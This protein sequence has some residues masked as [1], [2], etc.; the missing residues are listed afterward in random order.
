MNE[1]EINF[2]VLKTLSF[3]HLITQVGNHS[4]SITNISIYSKKMFALS[5]YFQDVS[6]FFI[7]A[8]KLNESGF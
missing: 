4:I 2:S 6:I 3:K 7:I 8:M 5:S 1:I